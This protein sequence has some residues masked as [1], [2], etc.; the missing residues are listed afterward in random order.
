MRY[1]DSITLMITNISLKW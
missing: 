1:I